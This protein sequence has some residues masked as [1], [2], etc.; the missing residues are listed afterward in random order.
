MSALPAAATGGAKAK[1]EAALDRA[2]TKPVRRAGE[3]GRED[4]P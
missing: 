2:P 4:R 3:N 1:G